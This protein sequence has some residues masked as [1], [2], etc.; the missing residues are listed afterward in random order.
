MTIICCRYCRVERVKI[1]L[2]DGSAEIFCFDCDGIAVSAV[3][4]Q[5]RRR[6]ALVSVRTDSR[7][8][9]RRPVRR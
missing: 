4:K 7:S 3:R 1:A 9:K 8:R 6:M 2:A 5:P